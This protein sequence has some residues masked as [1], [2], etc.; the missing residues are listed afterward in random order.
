MRRVGLSA[1]YHSA[2]SMKEKTKSNP[3]EKVFFF[4]AK[5]LIDVTKKAWINLTEVA[6]LVE[7]AIVAFR[8]SKY[9]QTAFYKF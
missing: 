6:K 8:Y 4:I 3:Y 9:L 5:S 7:F 2:E 1:Q